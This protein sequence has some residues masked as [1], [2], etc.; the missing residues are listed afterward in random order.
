MPT[1]KINLSTL[2]KKV[3][4]VRGDKCPSCW[5]GCYSFEMKNGERKH[6]SRIGKSWNDVGLAEVCGCGCE[7]PHF[8]NETISFDET[9]KK[10]MITRPLKKEANKK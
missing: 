3:G 9:K 4:A 8:S 2:I 10:W 7:V 5:M 1:G 6:I